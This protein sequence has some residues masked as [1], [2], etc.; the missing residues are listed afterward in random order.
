VDELAQHRRGGVRHRS[1]TVTGDSGIVTD[2]SGIVTDDSG[3]R[4]KS[5]T[6][7]PESPV[8]LRRN[9]RS[10]WTGMTGHDRPE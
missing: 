3:R 6:F 5:V 9:R 10:R 2:R 8:T 7:S 4:P 1:G